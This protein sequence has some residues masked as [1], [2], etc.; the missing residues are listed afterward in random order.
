ML[1]EQEAAVVD[2]RQPGPEATGEPLGLVLVADDPLD[3]LPFHAERRVGE[4][5]V[6]G[7]PRKV[8]LRERVAHPDAGCV[9]TL[10]HHVGAAHRIGLSI[11]FLPEYLQ[12]RLRVEVAQMVLGDGEHAARPAGW[13]EEGLDHAR[14]GQ[15]AVVLDEEEVDH[16]PDDLAGRE[17]LTRSLVGELRESADQLLVQVAHLQVADR[18]GM[19]V[20]LAEPGNDEV[21]QVRTIKPV[22]L[23]PEVELVEDIASRR[24]EVGDVGQQVVSDAV[25]VVEQPAQV[26][27][28]GVVELLA[29]NLPQHGIDVRD[30][31]L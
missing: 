18:L 30:P 4:Q 16:E 10:Q 17:M 7:L 1:K 12:P 6:E 31:S 11:Q 15:Q 5:V 22:D 8:V 23:G 19:Q 14:L 20:D 2:P 21:E 26:E 24:R 28:G 25:R 3:L 9:L 13:V 29:C 27:R